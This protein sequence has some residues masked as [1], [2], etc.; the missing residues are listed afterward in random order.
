MKPND[1]KHRLASIYSTK[2]TGV[3]VPILTEMLYD[4]MKKENENV[5]RGAIRK[6]IEQHPTVLQATKK[7][8]LMMCPAEDNQ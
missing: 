3:P 1:L 2:E 8:F 6:L 5:S 7:L 4:V